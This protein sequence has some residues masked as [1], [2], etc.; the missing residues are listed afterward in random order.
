MT[1]ANHHDQ[2]T[3][4]NLAERGLSPELKAA[5]I[6]GGHKP[7]SALGDNRIIG[8]ITRQIESVRNGDMSRA[9]GI[10]VAQAEALDVIF[11][12]LLGNAERASDQDSKASFI[13]MAVKAQEGCLSALE[14]LARI[15]SMF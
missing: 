13:S 8:E 7:Y 6:I 1:T 12:S 9:E 15:K 10:L 3:P 2:I 14:G 5:S 11:Y 4:E